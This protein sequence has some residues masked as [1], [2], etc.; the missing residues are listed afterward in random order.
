MDDEI[1]VGGNM[2]IYGMFLSYIQ[3][4]KKIII[5]TSK[6]TQALIDLL[7]YSFI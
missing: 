4:H 5:H 7:E 1:L 6:S 3:F 2:K